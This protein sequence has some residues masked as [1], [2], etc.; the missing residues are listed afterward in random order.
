MSA[1]TLIT[2]ELGS[3]IFTSIEMPRSCEI[4]RESEVNNAGLQSAREDQLSRVVDV[5]EEAT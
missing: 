3:K 4:F 1:L 5:L 2:Q